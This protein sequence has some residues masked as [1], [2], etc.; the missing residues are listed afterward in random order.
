MLLSL[1]CFAGCTPEADDPFEGVDL[2]RLNR[3]KSAVAAAEPAVPVALVGPWLEPKQLPLETWYLQYI[4]GKR[5]GYLKVQADRS[6]TGLFRIQ[7]TAV[8]ELQIETK[9]RQYRVDLESLEYADGRLVSFVEK[10]TTGDAVTEISGQMRDQRLYMESQVNDTKK[11]SSLKW[12]DGTWGVLDLQSILAHKPIT[13]GEQRKANVFVPRMQKIIPVEIL[14]GT[15]EITALP[16][17]QT[18]ELIPVEVIMTSGETAIRS[19]NW[20]NKSGEILKSATTD[21]SLVSTFRA[22]A[23]IGQRCADELQFRLLFAKRAPLV[24]RLLKPEAKSVTYLIEADR[25]LYSMWVQDARQSVQSKSAL[26][27]EVTVRRN[28]SPRSSEIETSDAAVDA[29]T[30][31]DRQASPLVQSDHP[32]IAELAQELLAGTD[33]P[34]GATG[35]AAVIAKLTQALPKRTST[36]A[37]DGDVHGAVETARRL[38]GDC[39]EH[40]ILLTALLRN[41]RIPARVVVGL[42]ADFSAD[43][44]AFHMWTEAWLNEQWRAVDGFTGDIAGVD[45]LAMQHS[46]LPKANPFPPMLKVFENLDSLSVRVLSSE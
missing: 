9:L 17:G 8:F 3:P 32:L 26:S 31:A 45:Y 46:S 28:A 6:E 42:K 12:Q 1:G 18:P 11:K 4:G 36:N 38:D 44:L 14:A 19:K 20:V 35:D 39:V 16:G 10:T 2:E 24:S 43:S 29:P 27:N 33:R 13:P 7:K 23:E 37:L 22:P 15:P 5:I 34:E 30:E 21:G 41:Q 25:D 40:A